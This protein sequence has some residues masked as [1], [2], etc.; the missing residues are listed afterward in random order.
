MTVKDR[1]ERVDFAPNRTPGGGGHQVVVETQ[2]V[3]IA[4]AARGQDIVKET[5]VEL[6]PLLVGEP[7]IDTVIE[8]QGTEDNL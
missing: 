5:A 6:P 1:P 2:V 8:R 7:G 3:K 4:A